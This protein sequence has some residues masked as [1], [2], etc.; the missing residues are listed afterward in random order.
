MALIRR[1]PRRWWLP[2]ARSR[3]SRSAPCSRLTSRRSSSTRSSTSS[4]RC[5]RASCA[6]T[7]WGWPHEAGVDVGE[8]YRVD[9]SRRTTGANAY[10][11]GLGHTKRVVLYDNLIK[12]FSPRPGAL[13]GRARARA[14]EATATCRA[15]CSG[16]RS[17]RPP[18]CSPSSGSRERLAPRSGRRRRGPGSCRR[19]RS[20]SPRRRSCS[21]SPA[22]RSRGGSR[23]A[24]TP[25]RSSSTDDPEAFIDLERSSRSS[26]V[27]DPDPPELLQAA[28]R[29]PS[30]DASSGIGAV[31]RRYEDD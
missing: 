3:W 19:W 2:G 12:D 14:R 4:S 11:N 7:C 20:R 30:D 6:P 9:A 5:P 22:T 27:C 17:W 31:P 29:H 18:G 13:G 21:G 8:V 15:G 24:P 23:R 1:F 25:T 28:V 26:N 10:V 16:S